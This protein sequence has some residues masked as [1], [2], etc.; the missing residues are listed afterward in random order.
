MVC[1]LNR[2]EFADLLLRDVDGMVDCELRQHLQQ[3]ALE[4]NKRLA[5]GADRH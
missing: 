2:H 3:F 4:I 1:Y 5:S